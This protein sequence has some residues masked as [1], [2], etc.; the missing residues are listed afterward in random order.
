MICCRSSFAQIFKYF[1][2][3]VKNAHDETYY[4]F[5]FNL[6]LFNICIGTNEKQEIFFRLFRKIHPTNL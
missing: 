3:F 1:P 4:L 2:S 6:M 5:I